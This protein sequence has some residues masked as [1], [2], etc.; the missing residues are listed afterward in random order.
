MA[1]TKGAAIFLHAGNNGR[2]DESDEQKKVAS[3]LELTPD[4]WTVMTKKVASFF[5]GKTGS[6]APG[7]G[8]P[9]FFC[10]GPC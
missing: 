2:V 10:T 5:P 6:A 3:F 7:D 4:T 1:P 8:P 9:L